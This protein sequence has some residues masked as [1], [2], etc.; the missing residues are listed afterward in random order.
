MK[1]R[2]AVSRTS[3]AIVGL[4]RK[5]RKAK[6]QCVFCER[7]FFFLYFSFLESEVAGTWVAIVVELLLDVDHVATGVLQ[8]SELGS[9]T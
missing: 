5:I 7:G 8:L 1:R 6:G 9:A 4:F 3:E 2:R